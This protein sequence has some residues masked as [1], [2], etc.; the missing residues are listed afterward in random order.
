MSKVRP[1]NDDSGKHVGYI[2]DCPGCKSTHIVHVFERNR[3]N[4]Q[5]SFNGDMEKPTF[6]PS[7]NQRVGPFPQGAKRYGQD[8]SGKFDVCHVTVTDGI[9]DFHGDCSHEFA[10]KQLP[11]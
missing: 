4:A 5:W 8:W 3:C 9:C 1:Y 11:L 7:L 2:F 10:G 6:R